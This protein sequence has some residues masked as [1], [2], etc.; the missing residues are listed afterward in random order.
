MGSNAP[1]LQ[2]E[3]QFISGTYLGMLPHELSPFFD[4]EHFISIRRIQ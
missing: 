4:L 1:M 3:R 2:N